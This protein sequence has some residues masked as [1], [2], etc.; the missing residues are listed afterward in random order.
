MP[1]KIIFVSDNWYPNI[2]GLETSIKTLA[3]SIASQFNVTI[4][5]RAGKDTTP[6]SE[7]VH[8]ESL[9][10]DPVLGYYGAA[11]RIIESSA[12]D[13]QVIVHLFG[14]SFFWPEQQAIFVE[15]IKRKVGCPILLKSP[16][17]GHSS[18]YLGNESKALLNSVDIFIALTDEIARELRSQ[19]VRKERIRLVPNGVSTDDFYP[20]PLAPPVKNERPTLGFAGRFTD[21]KGLPMLLAGLEMTPPEFRPNIN[22]VGEADN[23]YGDGYVG[24][25]S[26]NENIVVTPFQRNMRPIFQGFDGYVSASVYEGM[27]NAVLE[28]MACGLPLILSD[29]PGHQDLV[30]E[31][32]NGWLFSD[33]EA[34]AICLKRFATMYSQDSLEKMGSR[35][36]EIVSERYS[37]DVLRR[38]YVELYNSLLN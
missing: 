13:R 22:L 11:A 27:P 33:K 20:N 23:T 26:E 24:L 10:T 1:P 29:I 14:Y 28:A 35:S 25:L 30:E 16:S 15:N 34:L 38:R 21:Q 17:L 4:L 12:L 19:N 31:G 18:K 32:Q 7:L 3:K 8:I 36:R 37:H 9:P 6:F 2:G 5:T